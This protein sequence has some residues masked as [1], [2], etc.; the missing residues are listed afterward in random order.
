MTLLCMSI[1]KWCCRN[2]TSVLQLV[3]SWN[4]P[5]HELTCWH[6]RRKI[7]NNKIYLDRSNEKSVSERQ[8][9]KQNVR[10]LKIVL[11]N[12]TNVHSAREFKQEVRFFFFFFLFSLF[13][14]PVRPFHFICLYMKRS[15]SKHSISLH[16]IPLVNERCSSP[17]QQTNGM[18]R[19]I[20]HIE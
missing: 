4:A 10:H 1:K 12:I 19:E 3:R 17:K 14:A 8:T 9:L 11:D 18:N 7:N 6:K 5:V 15:K 16:S 20:K 13:C 2:V